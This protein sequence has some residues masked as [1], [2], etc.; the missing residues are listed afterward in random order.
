MKRVG[1]G[2]GAAQPV[3]TPAIPAITL[4]R[5][6]I[7]CRLRRLILG[8]ELE[9]VTRAMI[10]SSNLVSKSVNNNVTLQIIGGKAENVV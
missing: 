5:R 10:V 3:R 6:A 9:Q 4:H 2:L 8:I 7:C 1:L